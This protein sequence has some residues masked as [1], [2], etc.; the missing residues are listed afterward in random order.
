[1]NVRVYILLWLFLSNTILI[2]GQDSHSINLRE[3]S[4]SFESYNSLF[5]GQKAYL[6]T[7]KKHY[8]AKERIWFRAYLTNARDFTPDTLSK[9][10]YA[11]LWSPS[12]VRVQVIRLELKQ[13]TTS[14]SFFLSDTLE[15]G[16]YQLRAFSDVMKNYSPG[17]Y[18]NKNIVIENPNHSN[19]ISKKTV[20]QNIKRLEL[21]R[22]EKK[23][24]DVSYSVEGGTLIAG[25]ENQVFLKASNKYGD[26]TNISGELYTSGKEKIL[27]FNEISRGL[28]RF[29]FI[30]KYKESYYLLVKTGEGKGH[31]VKLPEPENAGVW[32]QVEMLG[33]TVNL[34][35]GK[36]FR[37][38]DDPSANRYYVLMHSGGV[39]KKANVVDL[40]SDTTLRYFVDD[41]LKGLVNYSVINNRGQNVS[42]FKFFIPF[43]APAFFF[44][45]HVEN[46]KDS[47]SLNLEFDSHVDFHSVSLAVTIQDS[48]LLDYKGITGSY[49]M[50]SELNGFSPFS[51]S[52]QGNTQPESINLFVQTTENI[53]PDWNLVFSSQEIGLPLNQENLIELKGK[54]TTELLDLPLK[55]ANVRL[56]VLDTYNDVFETT[57]DE[58]G[59]FKFQ[60][61][62]FYDT[63]NMKLLARKRSGK[64]N[65]LIH[66]EDYKSPKPVE[67]N[68]DFFLTTVS[69]RNKKKFREEQA[70]LHAERAMEEEKE[71]NKKYSGVLHG[72]PDQIIYGDELPSNQSLLKSLVGRVPGLQ[73]SGDQVVLRGVNSITGSSNPLVL[74][75]DIPT[76]VS[77]LNNI[78]VEDVDRVEIIKGPSASIYGLR[79]GNGVIA[80]YFK[81][82][83]FAIKGELDFSMVGYHRPEEFIRTH[84]REDETK[85][86]GT[87]LW[88][89][90]LNVQDQKSLRLS[91]PR[92]RAGKYYQIVIEGFTVKNGP[93]TIIENSPLH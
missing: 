80:V 23:K 10:L 63:L 89:D 2:F 64:K 60:G 11:E 20:R 92:P 27:Y 18:F 88:L 73:V 34:R 67:Y 93:F 51:F 24:F 71:L 32:G 43:V 26:L 56:E 12:G 61:L 49:Y 81:R 16:V 35:L 72:R 40:R 39:L 65:L 74:V 4:N 17:F 78:S 19:L 87:L 25:K 21:I 7:D 86:P 6:H 14:G 66:L 28:A 75:D 68:G 9:N 52:S 37:R 53:T 83:A 90:N 91:F 5:P 50:D 41:N 85:L 58:K 1:M 48:I 13:G 22:R 70:Q 84:S 44:E 59:R 33:D 46:S 36:P 55:G 82:G 76:D 62:S 31:K 57:T 42:N 54:I 15:Q 3:I 30:P 8:F 47:V 69:T 38:S 79:G 45:V 29:A 77:V